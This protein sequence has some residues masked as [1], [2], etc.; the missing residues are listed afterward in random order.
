MESGKITDEDTLLF[1]PTNQTVKVK[2][3]ESWPTPKKEYNKGE[4]LG[5]TLE[6]QIFVDVGNIASKPDKPPKLMNRFEAN[7]FWLSQNKLK[8]NKKYDLKINT[9]QY[10]VNI[11]EIKKIINTNDLQSKKSFD[12]NKNDICELVFHSSQLIPMDNYSHIKSTGRFCL[13]DE[14]EIVAGG[15]LNLRNFPDQ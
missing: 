1:L 10:Q 6:E 9:G 11:N 14:N 5:I 15:I 3:L 8:L 13:L 2:S 12:V 7:V 4:C